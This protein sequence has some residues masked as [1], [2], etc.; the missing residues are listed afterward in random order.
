M[1]GPYLEGL[2]HGADDELLLAGNCAAVVAQVF[3]QL[4]VDCPAARH[5]RVVLHGAPIQ[6]DF[7]VRPYNGGGKAEL[8]I[9]IR[10]D[11]EILAWGVDP[12]PETG[13]DRFDNI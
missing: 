12:H 1:L 7:L 13:F 3:G 10:K 5:H 6:K 9:R 2:G 8:R 11:L 4:H